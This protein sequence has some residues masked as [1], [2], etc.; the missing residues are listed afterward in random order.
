MI[1][2]PHPDWQLTNKDI[3]KDILV[4]LLREEMQITKQ[5]FGA[6]ITI[7]CAGDNCHIWPVA[8][9]RSCIKK[10]MIS[11]TSVT[12]NYIIQPT[13]LAKH[14]KTLEWLSA[15]ILWKHELA[16]F[17][18]LLDQYAPKFTTTSEKATIDHFQNLITYYRF[19]LIDALTS[20][21]RL[22]EKKL[23]EMLE[24]KDETMVEYFQEH[25]SLMGELEA[26]NTQLTQ[27]KEALF[28]FIERA[29]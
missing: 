10:V 12:E 14:R 4:V 23:A 11:V 21:L 18:K 22:H 29:M 5:A 20:R 24:T 17:Q 9:K 6:M 27:N 8:E 15:A 26:A 13:L 19:E 1:D 16:F 2:V 7:N 3:Y 28:L 25:D